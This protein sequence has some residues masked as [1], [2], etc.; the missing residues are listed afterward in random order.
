MLKD[1]AQQYYLNGYNCAESIIRAGNDYYQLGL[2]DHDMKM[3][4]AF[5]GGM[6]IGDVCGV[7]TSS[8][9]IISSKYVETK[10]HDQQKDLQKITVKMITTFQKRFQSRKCSEIKPNFFEPKV[11]CQNTVTIACEMLE[12]I[13][14]EYDQSI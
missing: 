7:F 10:A 1:V 3:M 13:I 11:R 4:A 14:N 9:A 6:M 5:G 2:H 12:D 8:A